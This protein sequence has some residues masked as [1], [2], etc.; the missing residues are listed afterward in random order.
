MAVE[1]RTA[2][3]LLRPFRADDEAAFAAFVDDPRYRRH[4]GPSHPGGAAVFVAHNVAVDWEREPSWVICIDDAPVG[5]IF[6]GVQP[7]DALAE[8]ACLLAPSAWGKGIAIEAG[9][10]VVDYA[11]AALGLYKVF[12][13]AAAPNAASRR[14]MEKAGMREEALLRSHRVD[15]LGARVDEAICSIRRDEWVAANAGRGP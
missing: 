13:R 14:A 15:A 1:L 3:L 7:D 8:L 10:A 4:L 11:F 2:R 12:A 5:S 6:L 9:R